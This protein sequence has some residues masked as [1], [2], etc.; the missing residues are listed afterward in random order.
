LL[1]VISDSRGKIFLR[2][3]IERTK[4]MKLM[5]RILL[6]LVY[7]AS[8][9]DALSLFEDVAISDAETATLV[10]VVG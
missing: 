2:E 5:A 6:M 8:F 1:H 9:A 3:I 4:T 7:S 10:L